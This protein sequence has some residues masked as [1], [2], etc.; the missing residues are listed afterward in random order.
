MDGNGT[1]AGVAEDGRQLLL[2]C[3]GELVEIVELD[4]APAEPGDEWRWGRRV[5]HALRTASR[6][7]GL[8]LPEESCG[9]LVKAAV[10]EPDP[11]FNRWYLEPA[12]NAFGRR[13]VRSTLLEFLWTGSD[14]ERAG[15]ARAWYWSA[16]QLQ[17]PE[18]RAA[19][20]GVGCQREEDDRFVLTSEWYEAALREFVSSDH[21]GVQCSIIPRLPLQKSYYPPELHDLVDTALALA[22]SHPND[23]IRHRVA[24]PPRVRDPRIG[25]RPKPWSRKPL[26]PGSG[27]GATMPG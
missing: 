3:L 25:P 11:S 2:R 20:E 17:L 6:K 7:G 26:D 23:Y 18:V 1:A 15:A 10:Y 22:R 8:L 13:R 5:G 14:L 24:P 4:V 27:G 21:L 19:E 9:T 16:L 12:L